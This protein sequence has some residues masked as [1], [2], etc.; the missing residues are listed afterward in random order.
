MPTPIWRTSGYGLP[1]CRVW[2]YWD[3]EQ[4]VTLEG[5]PA[6]ALVMA[7]AGQALIAIASYGP[8][9]EARLALDARTLGLP[10]DLK[11]VNAETGEP[12]AR[13]MDGSFRFLLPRHDFRLIAVGRP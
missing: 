13:N 12:V 1:D 2:R 7:R 8:D 3:K 4:P 11:A 6:K 10:K 9:G 5:A